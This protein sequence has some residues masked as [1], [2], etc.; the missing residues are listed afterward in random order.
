MRI[1]IRDMIEKWPTYRADNSTHPFTATQI[2]TTATIL[3]HYH[4][5][6]AMQWKQLNLQ[7]YNK[8]NKYARK[9]SRLKVVGANN[10]KNAFDMYLQFLHATA[11]T[12]IA[13]LSHRN[14]VRLSVCLSVCLSLGW[15]RQKR[16]KLGSSN[17][18]H[19]GL[20]FCRQKPVSAVPV[21]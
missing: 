14:S 8:I 3:Q 21:V 10:G 15:I 6:N 7:Q 20:G 11:G 13:R 19:Q 16:C 12:A 17:L 5:K 2:N 18:H 4:N 9:T 1:I